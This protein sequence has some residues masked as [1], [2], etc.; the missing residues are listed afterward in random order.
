LS[1]LGIQGDI[2]NM[3]LLDFGVGN[4]SDFYN[5][6]IQNNLDKRILVFNQGVDSSALEDYS[7]RILEWNQQDKHIPKDK[8]TPITIYIN[9]A[10]GDVFEGMNII[11]IIENS[12]TPIRGVCFSMAA[13]M[14]L[15]IFMACHEK[16]AF[17]N[18]V[19]LMHDGQIEIA[20][21]GSKARNTMDFIDDNAKR[22]KQ[23]ILSHS[24]MSEEF[25]DSNYEK[26]YFMYAD[27]DGK[28][29]GIVDHII[30]IDVSLDDII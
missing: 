7:L 26:E 5:E 14:G 4:T 10:G 11:D 3:D 22:V 27:E 1:K 9:C 17:R 23:F 24:K 6:I 8:R 19:L 30:G 25:Y 13:S 28:E 15:L 20:N 12:I 21:S 2:K 16:F 29:L 18:S